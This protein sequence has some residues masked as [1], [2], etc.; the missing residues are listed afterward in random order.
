[1]ILLPYAHERQTVQRLPYITFGLI[2]LNVIIFLLTHYGT[3]SIDEY[4]SK[5]D[6]YQQYVY[7]HH[8]LKIPDEGRK[9]FEKWQLD[10]LDT[11]HEAANLSNM[12]AETLRQ[13]QER[14]DSMVREIQTLQ[15]A[16]PYDRWGYSPANPR[17]ITLFTCMFIHSG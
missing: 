7:A 14:L 12:D 1:M 5:L 11:L 13:E 3:S 10:E 8:Y 9:Y 6:Q 16:N 4:Y 17:L 2:A 15:K